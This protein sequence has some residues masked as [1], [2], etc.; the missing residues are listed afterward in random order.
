MKRIA[1]NGFGRIGK[2]FLRVIMADAAAKKDLEVVAINIGPAKTDLIGH[3]FQYDTLMGKFPGTV[4]QRGN[5]LIIDGKKIALI[6]EK[7]PAN[8]NWAALKIDWVV[9]CSGKFTHR[10]DAEK[11]LKAGAKKV[12][13]SAPATDEDVSIIPGV[14]DAMYD[15]KKH[16]IVSLGSCTTNAVFPLLKV[17]HDQCG[18]EQAM[19]MTTHAYTN[20]QVLLDVEA[21]DPR[22]SRAAA[23]NIIP[24]STGAAKMVPK[25]M[26]ALA[27]KVEMSSVRVPVGKVSLIELT[28]LSTKK[29]SAEIINTAFI[30]ASKQSMRGIIEVES[31]PLVSSDFSGNSS[32]VILDAPLTRSLGTLSSVFGWYDNEWGYSCRL[33]DFLMR[34]A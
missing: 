33:K 1:I 2:T 24:T 29:L 11:H 19:M 28:F 14:N 22:T 9:E 21:K 5:E 18:L 13:I 25:V 26:P 17:L 32:S 10:E 7:D 16:N 31:K 34:D 3:L 4:E 30:D 23:L 20:T 8:L 27:G 15:A 12:L 6:A